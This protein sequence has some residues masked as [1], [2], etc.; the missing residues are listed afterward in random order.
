[1]GNGWIMFVRLK[2]YNKNG[3]QMV[4]SSCSGK[5]RVKRGLCIK[6]EF[7]LLYQVS[8]LKY[9]LNFTVLSTE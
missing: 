1:M 2:K 4:T 9:G 3:G 8:T 6:T 5:R 7:L